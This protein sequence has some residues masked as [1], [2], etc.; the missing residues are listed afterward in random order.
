MLTGF[1][2]LGFDSFDFIESGSVKRVFVDFN[3]LIIIILY[4]DTGGQILNSRSF[5]KDE[6]ETVFMQVVQRIDEINAGYDE[7][8]VKISFDREDD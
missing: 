2:D 4:G 5:K 6:I 8:G 3:R 1:S 7:D